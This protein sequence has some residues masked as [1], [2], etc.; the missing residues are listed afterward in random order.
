MATPT[1]DEVIN[2]GGA[3]CDL[4]IGINILEL[5]RAWDPPTTASDDV[6]LGLGN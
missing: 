6:K 1:D 2:N 4:E 5:A 3:L